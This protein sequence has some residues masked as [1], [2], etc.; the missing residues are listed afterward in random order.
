MVGRQLDI[1]VCPDDENRAVADLAGKEPKQQDRSRVGRLEIIEDDDER[2]IATDV[3]QEGR[4]RIEQLE[5]SRF[6]FRVSRRRKIRERPRS[7]GNNW[8]TSLAPAP[9]WRLMTSGAVVRR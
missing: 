7:S 1:T 5:A 6:G 8:A 3:P 4:G 9:T 2:S